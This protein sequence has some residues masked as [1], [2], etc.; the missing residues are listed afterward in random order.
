VGDAAG[1]HAERFEL[2]RF[3]QVRLIS[4]FLGDVDGS[5][6]TRRKKII[7]TKPRL[8]LG[9]KMPGRSMVS[10]INLVGGFQFFVKL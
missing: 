3:Q 9:Y 10:E 2:F 7:N 1:K 6:M 4:A 8:Q 5:G